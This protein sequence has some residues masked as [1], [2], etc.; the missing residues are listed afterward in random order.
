MTFSASGTLYCAVARQPSPPFFSE[1][2]VFDRAQYARA[3]GREVGDRTVTSML[4]QHLKAGNIRR[5]ARGVFASVPKH[6]DPATWSADRFLAASRLRAGGVIGYH[7]ALQLLG[8]A[9]SEG[10]DLQVIA[11]GQPA[12]LATANFACRFVSPPAPF[13]DDDVAT[14]DRL[15]QTVRVTTLECTIADLFD[16]PDLAGGA[17]ELMNSLDLVGRLDARL[18][19]SRLEALGNATAVG[20]AGWWL[21][22]N[23]ER[24]GVADAILDALRALAP[25]QNRYALGA[26]PGCGKLAR[27]WKVILPE[28]VLNPSFEGQA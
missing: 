14:V 8:Y 21:E 13:A 5:I 9:Y 2:P 23:Q 26:R 16:R 17:E 15:G 6:A 20:A 28:A 18:L 24:L 25:R 12:I 27:G 11:P 19:L 4:S 10:F 7:S 22:A 1:T 3:V